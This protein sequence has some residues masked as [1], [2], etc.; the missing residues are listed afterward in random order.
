MPIDVLSRELIS[1][2]FS[3]SLASSVKLRIVSLAALVVARLSACITYVSSA[4][5][6]VF[7]SH[8]IVLSLYAVPLKE[9]RTMLSN[10][11]MAVALTSHTAASS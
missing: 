9:A 5:I 3:T 11:A 7:L 4:S 8:Y 10:E 1:L 6:A 2:F